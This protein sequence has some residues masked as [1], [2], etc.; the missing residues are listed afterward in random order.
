MINDTEMASEA[1]QKHARELYD[2]ATNPETDRRSRGQYWGEL[3]QFKKTCKKGWD[4]LG[5][6]EREVERAKTNK[7]DWI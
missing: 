2:K 6:T 3:W 5:F 4:A 7:P 1:R